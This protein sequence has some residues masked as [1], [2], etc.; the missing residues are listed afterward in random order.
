M[1]VRA[2]LTLRNE[3]VL[4]AR[5]KLGLSQAALAEI[6]DVNTGQVAAVECMRFSEVSEQKIVRI[7][8][9]LDLMPED[10]VPPELAGKVLPT[11]FVS[12]RDISSD[13][14]LSQGNR[15]IK[16]LDINNSI[17]EWRAV[18]GLICTYREAEILS[19]KMGGGTL[20]KMAEKFKVSRECVRQV[21]GRAVRKIER[22]SLS[23]G[24]EY[25][26]RA[27][28]I[29]SVLESI[30]LASGP[31]LDAEM[32]AKIKKKVEALWPE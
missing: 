10:V 30:G 21:I 32:D 26:S 11:K 22:R 13:R 4:S 18:I 31:H 9:A 25:Y 3:R 28:E 5:K 15:E 20:S 17:A 1:L 19:L 16:V 2:T 23:T 14:I 8:G 12:I 24:M 27:K 29:M 6:A 7:A